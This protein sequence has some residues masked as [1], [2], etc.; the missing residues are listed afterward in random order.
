[1][2]KHRAFPKNA[3]V[4]LIGAAS[5]STSKIDHLRG[6]LATVG[7][8]QIKYWTFFKPFCYRLERELGEYLGDPSCVALSSAK[9]DF[10]FDQGSY[11]QAGIGFKN[12]KFVV[13]LMFRLM[14]LKDD[15]DTLIRVLPLF[16]LEGDNLTVGFEGK[17]SKTSSTE[18]IEP[19]LEYIYEHLVSCCSKSAWFAE[20]PDH[21]QGTAIGFA[22]G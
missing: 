18:N 12:G 22:C 16:T 2:Q 5:M 20:N 21:Y 3:H 7:Q 1:M 19:V 8:E 6:L 9:G 13:P 15:G 11:C 17:T 14:N 4:V 10:T